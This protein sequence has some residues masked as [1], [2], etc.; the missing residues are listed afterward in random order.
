[1][2]IRVGYELGK[3][4]TKVDVHNSSSR[5]SSKGGNDPKKLNEA[6]ER[7]QKTKT[8]TG[9]EVG[10]MV[11]VC[12]NCLFRSLCDAK[13]MR[14]ELG[15]ERYDNNQTTS[16][17]LLLYNSRVHTTPRKAYYASKVCTQAMKG[18]EEPSGIRRRV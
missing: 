7:K 17:A 11:D 4:S 13:I 1:M 10:A 5:S 18:T 6:S 14:V 12:V 2:L 8:C 15:S 3:T 9:G 16:T